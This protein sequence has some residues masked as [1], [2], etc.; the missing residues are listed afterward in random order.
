MNIAGMLNATCSIISIAQSRTATGGVIDTE[1][2]YASSVPCAMK[3]LSGTEAL[4]YG[5]DNKEKFVRFYFKGTQTISH[6]NKI[7]FNNEYYNILDIYDVSFKGELLHVD[8]KLDV[9][10]TLTTGY[11]S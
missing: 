6:S 4:K 5:S 9:V 10:P 8:T 2:V 1:S 7:L 11:D 3:L